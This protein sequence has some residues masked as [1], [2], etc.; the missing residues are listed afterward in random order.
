MMLPYR[1][2]CNKKELPRRRSKLSIACSKEEEVKV[3]DG[4][5]SIIN[6]VKREEYSTYCVEHEESLVRQEM[7]ASIVRKV[8]ITLI[9]N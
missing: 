4:K 1:Y 9:R 2:A 8:L 7:T 6:S 5:D 3:E